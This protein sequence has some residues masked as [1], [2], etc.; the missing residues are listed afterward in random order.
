MAAERPTEG[1]AMT[2]S[3]SLLARLRATVGPSQVLT[4]DRQT[5]RYRKGYR[6]GEG[7]VLAVVRPGTLVEMWRV[8]QAAV[9]AGCAVILQAANTGLTGAPRPTATATAGRCCWSARCAWTASG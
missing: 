1:P 5:R 8:L 9:E 6:F 2:T 3:D 4:G 7:P